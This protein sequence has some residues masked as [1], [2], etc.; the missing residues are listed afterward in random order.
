MSARKSSWG[1]GRTNWSSR[2][3]WTDCRRA[4]V[5]S[6]RGLKT[7]TRASAISG[8]P[9]Q[10]PPA[11]RPAKRPPAPD[12]ESIAHVHPAAG[13]DVT[14]DGGVLL[15]G[16]VAFR[17]LPVSALPEVDYP[18]IQIATTYPG[19]SPDVMASSVTAPLE[20]QLGQMPGLQEMTSTS[21]TGLSLIT[22]QFALELSIDVAEQQVQQSINGAGTFLPA[23]LP[24]P[25]IYSKVNPADAPILTLALTSD[26]LP[27]STVQDLADTR[28]APKISQLR[29]RGA[30]HAQ[31][32]PEAGRPHPREPDHAG[33]LRLEPR[34]RAVGGHRDQRQPGQGQLRRTAAELSDRRQRSAA[35]EQRLRARWWW[36]TGTVRRFG[37]AT[38]DRRRLRRERAAGRADE[39]DAG[40]DS[41][42]AAAAGRQ[43]H[44]RCR[45]HQEA[46][47]EPDRDAAGSRDG[48]RA[49]RSHEHHPRLREG[50]GVRA[51]AH[52]RPRRGRDLSVPAHA[53][54]D[55]SFRASPCRSRSSAPSR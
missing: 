51:D 55:T 48:R 53:L 5:L 37:C 7:K 52:D 6:R 29:G 35:L 30:G 19:A 22:L 40:R 45:Q 2:R 13:R 3:A 9:A 16:V 23:D 18:T 44:H 20:R 25:P 41:Q 46:A 54:G 11:E 10:S 24:T 8:S 38:C 36:R 27:L 28:L 17:Q 39:R 50:R 34:R 47:A 31:R 33:V 32:R 14:V 15:A 21:S 26:T 43:H 49:D 1:S 42:C 12:H 4:A